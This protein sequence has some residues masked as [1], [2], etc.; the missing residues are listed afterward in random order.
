MAAINSPLIS[1]GVPKELMQAV[2][3]NSSLWNCL[4]A[5]EYSS[6]RLRLLRLC[7]LRQFVHQIHTK[8]SEMMAGEENPDLTEF[9]RCEEYLNQSFS[10]LELEELSLENV[11]ELAL[12]GKVDPHFRRPKPVIKKSVLESENYGQLKNILNSDRLTR[13]DR[14]WELEIALEAVKARWNFEI[15]SATCEVHEV[16]SF[17]RALAEKL[18]PNA[19]VLFIESGG[20]T[21]VGPSSDSISGGSEKVY[22]RGHWFLALDPSWSKS[23][24][25]I[26]FPQAHFQWAPLSSLSEGSH[27]SAFGRDRK[28]ASR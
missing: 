10:R 11:I 19:V 13:P 16:E 3:R 12:K 7:L 5:P 26:N 18:W 27:A 8:R 25:E 15:L 17:S 28:S 6:D 22:W 1:R 23:L 9:T 2:E 20:L 24:T 4:A 14:Y 21:S